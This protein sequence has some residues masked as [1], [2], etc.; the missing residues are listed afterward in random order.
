M[1]I[2]SLKMFCD[3]IDTQ[4]FSKT[5]ALN[6]VTQSAVS[7]QIKSMEKRQGKPLLERNKRQISLTAEGEIFFRSSREI[8]H[9]Y[10][11]MLSRIEA[12]EGVVSGTVRLSAIYSVGMREL[13]PYLKNYLKA[14]PK[15]NFKLEYEMARDIYEHVARSDI[16]LGIVAYP[17]AQRNVD[18]IPFTKDHMVVACHPSNPL[19]K[20]DAVDPLELVKHPLVLFSSENPT[21]QAIDRFL[22]KYKA[23]PNV[24]MELDHIDVIKDTVE[25]DLGISLVPAPSVEIEKDNGTLAVLPLKGEQLVRPLGILRRRGRNLSTATQKLLEILTADGDG[26]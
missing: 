12:L 15:V 10:D 5:A 23:T 19:A 7:Q 21:R 16:D 26:G 13:G 9:R 24:V 8:I 20:L 17:R 6:S 2:Q 3:L 25:V 1:L 14:H 18:V 22:R 4:S 11:E